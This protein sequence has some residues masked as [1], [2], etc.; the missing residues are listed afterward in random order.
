MAKVETHEALVDLI[1]R[2][3]HA[4]SVGIGRAVAAEGDMD[5]PVIFGVKG[6]PSYTEEGCPEVAWVAPVT[7]QEAV[8][9]ICAALE[10]YSP[11][12]SGGSY[13]EEVGWAYIS[14]LAIMADT[15][16]VTI[17]PDDE[18]PTSIIGPLSPWFPDA[19]V[20][21]DMPEGVKG[22]K[23]FMAYYYAL[24]GLGWPNFAEQV[25]PVSG[26]HD[27]ASRQAAHEKEGKGV[28]IHGIFGVDPEAEVFVL[29][30]GDQSTKGLDTKSTR[31]SAWEIGKPGG[32]VNIAKKNAIIAAACLRSGPDG[33]IIAELPDIM[34]MQYGAATCIARVARDPDMPKRKGATPEASFRAVPGASGPRPGVSKRGKGGRA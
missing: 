25:R 13:E 7:T 15:E 22:T 17:A 31:E 11:N 16:R 21:D 34:A 12:G 27:L 32:V 5:K 19:Q 6:F 20:I 30:M 23:A 3:A 8:D 14:A 4:R 1:Q 9:A 33:E 28:W 24:Q 2:D 29:P 26:K 10:Y 18:L